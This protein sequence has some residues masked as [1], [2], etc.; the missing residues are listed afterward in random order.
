[1]KKERILSLFLVLAM[2]VGLSSVAFA[3]DDTIIVK[4][5]NINVK[6]LPS[7]TTNVGENQKKIGRYIS[8]NEFDIA[9]VQED[10]GKHRQLVSA[11]DGY[12]YSTN[13]TGYVP[14]GD[15][16]NIF[17]R[18]M[19]IYNE[20]R[21]MWNA[22]HGVIEN[23]ADVLT[24]KGILYTVID[25]GNGIYVDFYDIHADAFGSDGDVAAREKNFEQL[26]SLITSNSEKYDRP[27][28]VTGDFNVYTHSPLNSKFPYYMHEL[29]SLKDA[30]TE[31]HNDGNYTQFGTWPSLGDPWGTWN[32]VEKFLY[33]SGG[34]VNIEALDFEYVWLR[35]E[36]NEKL[37]DHAA[38]VC[39][40]EFTKTEDY[41][42]NTQE[43]KIVKTYGTFFTHQLPWFF[44]A[45]RLIFENFNELISFLKT[46]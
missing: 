35:N 45:L 24:P 7:F 42:E 14:G 16:M 30:W 29:C 26:A 38:A 3:D 40:F 22:A 44:R 33:R 17:T 15:G 46:L 32:S 34:G 37:S 2:I 10:F 13:H 4:A 18:S 20:T 21:V 25:I 43:L 28:I 19:P 31:I 1:M 36:N 41:V 6:G 9:A 5:I 8:D 11:L 12:N 23:G 39:S 27:V